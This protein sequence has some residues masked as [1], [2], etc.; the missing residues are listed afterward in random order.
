VFHRH[1]TPPEVRSALD[2]LSAEQ[3]FLDP[4]AVGQ[5]LDEEGKF[6]PPER[7]VTYEVQR[8]P[9]PREHAEAVRQSHFHIVLRDGRPVAW[10]WSIRGDV[11]AEEGTVET[12]PEFRRRGYGRQALAAWAHD[13][14]GSGKRAFFRDRG[15]TPASESLARSLGATAIDRF[16][17]YP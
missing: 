3:M 8:R 16:I 2:R 12:V 7:G 1:P 14:V 11:H 13:I 5:L 6:S 17:R 15:I 10:A 4:A 9:D